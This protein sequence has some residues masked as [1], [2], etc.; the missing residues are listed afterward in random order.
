GKVVE[1][2]IFDP[3]MEAPEL[4]GRGLGS[5]VLREVI[6]KLREEGFSG[7]FGQLPAKE[8]AQRL[9]ERNGFRRIDFENDYRDP[10]SVWCMKLGE[11]RC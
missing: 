4:I 6:G 1:L 2:W 7:V 9:L 11:K 10:A 8:P 3:F 5:A